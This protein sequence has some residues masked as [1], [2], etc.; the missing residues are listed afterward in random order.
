MSHPMPADRIASLETLVAASPYR[1]VKDPA[2]L[3][4]R[5]DMMRAKLF[6]F[7]GRQDEVGRRYPAGD[8]TLPAQYARAILSYRYKRLGEALSRIDSLIAAQPGNPYFWE[9]KGQVLLEFGRP[10]E[11]IPA[12]RRAISLEPTAGLIRGMLGHALVATDDPGNR[13]EAINELT[14]AV[15]REPDDTGSYRHLATAYA[16]QG[17]IGMAELNTAQ[18]SFTMGDYSAAATHATRALKTLK[19][20][21]PAALKAEDIL[22]YRPKRLR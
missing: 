9:L 5:H 21:T 1:N 7:A 13:A 12:L 19:S 18:A 11:A 8:T 2:S 10:K 17:N 14:N 6:G 22:N 16:R 20:G 4:A 15:Q 3:Q